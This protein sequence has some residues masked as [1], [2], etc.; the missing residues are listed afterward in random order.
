VGSGELR[1]MGC[2]FKRGAKRSRRESGDGAWI[3]ALYRMYCTSSDFRHIT[4][5][6]VKLTGE[7]LAVHCRE[8]EWSNDASSSRKLYHLCI[9]PPDY[10][11]YPLYLD[12]YVQP[13]DRTKFQSPRVQPFSPPLKRSRCCSPDRSAIS[14]GMRMRM[15]Y[16]PGS[17]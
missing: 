9:S 12:M 6:T 5:G 17:P 4:Q 11:L 7:G 1:E 14:V 3:E 2:A 16:F 8:R 15:H 10:P 13:R